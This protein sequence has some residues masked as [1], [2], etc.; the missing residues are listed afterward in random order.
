LGATIRNIK[1][2]QIS[3]LTW[4]YVSPYVSLVLIMRM[5]LLSNDMESEVSYESAVEHPWLNRVNSLS[6]TGFW[7]YKTRCSSSFPH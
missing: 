4:S 1:Y 2:K 6:T 7:P 3:G 5:W